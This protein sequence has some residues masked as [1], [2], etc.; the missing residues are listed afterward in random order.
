MNTI[1]LVEHMSS[2][3]YMAVGSSY[4]IASTTP[5]REPQVAK[6]LSREDAYAAMT[7]WMHPMDCRVVEVSIEDGYVF[8]T[9]SKQINGMDGTRSFVITDANDPVLHT[10]LYL[11]LIREALHISL[12]EVADHLGTSVWTISTWE[13]DESYRYG[14]EDLYSA[15]HTYYSIKVRAS[16]EPYA[17]LAVAKMRLIQYTLEGW[18]EFPKEGK[19][20]LRRVQSW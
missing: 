19:A 4:P 8:S 15:L 14:R 9:Q 6:F 20:M 16:R 11:R 1:Y 7:N 10:H 17:V 12:A 13:N 3:T 18:F 5:L 2:K